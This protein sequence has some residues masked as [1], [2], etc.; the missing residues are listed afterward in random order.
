MLVYGDAW[1]EVAPDEALARLAGR[2]RRLA[3]MPAG[4]QRHAV[5]AEAFCQSAALAQGLAD[6]AFDAAGEETPG[7]QDSRAMALVM[8]LAAAL[9]QSWRSGFAQAGPPPELPR[10]PGPLP[11]RLRLRQPEGFA[12]YALYPEGHWQAA[13]ASGLGPGT[14]VIGL[15]SIGLALAAMVAAALGAAAPLTLRP[16]GPPFRRRL[17][18]SPALA[19]GLAAPAPAFAVVD[20]GPGLSGSSMAA[21]AEALLQAGQ[22]AERLHFFP[23]HAGPPGA[24]ASEAHRALWQRLPRHVAPMESLLLPGAR[25]EHALAAWLA[26]LT[27]PAE[28][29]LRDLSGGGWRALRYAREADWPPADSQQ[30]RRK[31]LVEAG[32]RRWLARFSG[33]GGTARRKAAMAQALSRAGFVPAWRGLRHGFSVEAWEEAE[34]LDQRPAEP[35]RLFGTVLRYLGFRAR[36]FPVPAG[37]GASPAALWEMACT[38]AGLALGEAAG[39]ALRRR[40]PDLAGL[41]AA[42]HPCR[43]DGRMQAWEWLVLADGRL[44]KAD[45]LDHHAAHDLVGCQDIAWDVAA[46]E[47]E[48]G[49]DGD[50]LLA[51]LGTLLGRAMPP[52]LLAFYRPCY[53]AFQLG[54]RS[55]AAAAHAH[56]PEEAARLA[57]TSRHAAALERLL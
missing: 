33:L 36:H 30:E 47:F 14:R 57:R 56:W 20:E 22:P 3:A 55:M 42:L 19:A 9:G 18:L 40:A 34:G 2:L 7:E 39:Q 5:L 17:A 35:A 53:L 41:A 46:A 45:A 8:R 1:Q 51:G 21:V 10:F 37:E 54:A 23:G 25:P 31:F 32:G 49:L 28:A 52:A 27:G 15:R 26:P 6:T 43:V 48:L 24:A 13:L 4:L 50:R 12:F 44:L 11:A 16:V 29:P 38:N